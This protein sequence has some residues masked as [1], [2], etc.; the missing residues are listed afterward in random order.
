M[1][2]EALGKSEQN[3]A[4]NRSVRGRSAVRE[5]SGSEASGAVGPVAALK[6][7]FPEYLMEAAGLGLF[8]VSACA[9]ALLLSHPQSPLVAGIGSSLVRRC[10]MGA[11][12]GLTAMAIVYS[13]WGQQSGAHLNPALTIT[14]FRLG[15]VAPWDAV[16]YGI[17]QVLGGLSG[18]LLVSLLVGRL[19]ADP[20]VNY[21]VTVPGPSGIGIAFVTELFI[22]FIQMTVV[23]WVSNSRWARWTGVCA[24]T[25][26]AL[27]ISTV[28]PLSGMS[29]NPARTL[30]SAIPA[31][32]W[33]GAWIYFT[34]PPLA[35]LAA[36]ETYLLTRGRSHLFC[37]K[38]HHQNS[39]R[40]IFCEFHG[41]H[42]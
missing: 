6:T 42:G 29:M 34:A 14:F 35:M 2:T 31:H 36:A 40:C 20:A 22:S 30:A 24:G 32:V 17:F 9:F 25:L 41:H 39:R 3:A 27:N 33:H 13:P 4:T 8:M 10:L 37:A 23:L 1:S 26:V 16:F 15:K 5:T 21:V 18:V 19:L 11:A 12:M 7:H 28:G 38:L